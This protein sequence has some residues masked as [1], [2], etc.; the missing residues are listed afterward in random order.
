MNID[1]KLLSKILATESNNTL[2]GSYTMIKCVLTQGCKNSSIYT[3]Q[4]M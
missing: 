2:K 3:N 4:L 1:E